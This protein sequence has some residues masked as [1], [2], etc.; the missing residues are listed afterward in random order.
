MFEETSMLQEFARY[1]KLHLTGFVPA[2]R[3]V[4]GSLLLL[5]LG[6]SALDAQ[7]FWRGPAGASSLEP[8]SEFTFVPLPKGCAVREK[9][10][11]SLTFAGR[12][13]HTL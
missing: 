6:S 12:F 2:T 11:I 5:L 7:E 1:A 13:R 4:V 9:L 8:K 10:V 3:W